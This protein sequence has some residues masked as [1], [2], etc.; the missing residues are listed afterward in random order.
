M[1]FRKFAKKGFEKYQDL[2]KIKTT[3]SKFSSYKHNTNKIIGLVK[4]FNEGENGNLFRCLNH[5]SVFCDDMVLCD[6]GSTDNSLEIARQFSSNIIQK[7]NDFK[8]ELF[9]KQELLDMALS[10]DPDWIVWLDPDETFDR[11]G[12]L[13]AIRG[14]TKFGDEN[15]IDS[16][17]FLFYNLWKGKKN[18]RIDE[19]WHKFRPTKLWKNTGKLKFNVNEGLHLR[20]HPQGLENTRR[21]DVKIIHYGFA[22]QEIIDKKYSTYKSHGQKGWALERIKDE[23]KLELKTFSRDWFPM[24]S[25]KISVVCL[26]YKS[27]NYAD[28]V[29]NSFKKHTEVKG[30]N[31]E[32]I[33]V[34]NDPTK[35]L[36]NYFNEKNIPYLL[37]RNKDPQ[38]YYLNRVY[39]AWNFGG[40]TVDGDIIIFVNSDMAFSD[41]WLDNLIK[42][43]TENRIITSR[44]VESGKMKSGKHGIENNF[45]RTFSEFTD[46]EFQKFAKK[47][48]SSEIKEGGLFMPCAI[49]KDL[50]VESG[51]Y[52]IGN[53]KEKNGKITPGD[54]ILF[55]ETL[56]PMGIKH[57]TAFDSIVYHIQEGE[58]DS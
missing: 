55:Y 39:R 4:F 19:L 8:K 42:N 32:F 13:D 27:I 17:S 58:M 2:K 37:F 50:F 41:N 6:D 31:I 44:L 47:I 22:S 28:F 24:S 35:D 18:Y 26:I 25:L 15:G 49:Y 43:L 53:R 52:P 9:H 7:P 34:A 33:F 20:Q 21:T 36:V 46:E 3:S 12:E 29:L 56:L 14:L 48:S 11:N 38:E 57:Y 5:L 23:K 30:R 16:F 1:V 51:G 40:S 45:G 54:K 10:L